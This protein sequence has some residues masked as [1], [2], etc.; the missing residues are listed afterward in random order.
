ML[1][2]HTSWKAVIAPYLCY[3]RT[4]K[5]E[6]GAEVRGDI[7]HVPFEYLL[8]PGHGHDDVAKRETEL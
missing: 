1:L 5:E 4:R 8:L 7:K 2:S 6:R 3:H